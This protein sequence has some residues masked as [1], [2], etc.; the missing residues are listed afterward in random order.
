MMNRRKKNGENGKKE[1]SGKSLS[2]LPFHLPAGFSA[3]WGEN[4]KDRKKGKKDTPRASIP[5]QPNPYNLSK[6]FIAD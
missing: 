3:R 5:A 6:F 2:R 4:E 1:S